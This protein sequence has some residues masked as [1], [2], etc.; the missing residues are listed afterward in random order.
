MALSAHHVPKPR[1]SCKEGPTPRCKKQ[2]VD[3]YSK[4]Y[5]HDKHYGKHAYSVS[6]ILNI[7]A[8]ILKNGPVEAD[9]TV[10]DD[11]LSYK[12][13]VYQRHSDHELGGHAIRILGWGTE[14]GTPYW[15]VANSWNTDWGDNGLNIL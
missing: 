10:Y 5:Q 11:F 4:S 6:G 14:N 2:C 1:P 13:G 15:L 12:S 3:G 8:E 7:Q 9:F